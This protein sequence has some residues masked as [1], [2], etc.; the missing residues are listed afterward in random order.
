[1]LKLSVKGW[2]GVAAVMLSAT[3][4]TAV[5][6]AWQAE[7][8]SRPAQACRLQIDSAVL[9]VV[10]VAKTLPQMARGL[11]GLDDVGEGMLFSWPDD[12]P[13]VFWMKGTPMPLSVAFL[14]ST[15]VVLQI[16]HMAPETETFHWS[17]LPA[18]EGLEVK[19][20]DFERLGIKPGSRVVSRECWSIQGE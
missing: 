7:L 12:A 4:A 20:G 16:E 6:K 1:M 10:P 11:S 2:A 18:R 17:R 19:Q 13:R 5:A 14:D 15:G 8:E 9:E 3:V